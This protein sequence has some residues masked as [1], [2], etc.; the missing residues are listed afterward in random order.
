MS[1]TAKIW[2]TFGA[3]VVAFFALC[4][5]GDLIRESWFYDRSSG[6]WTYTVAYYLTGIIF[7]A[8][9]FGLMKH[10]WRNGQRDRMVICVCWAGIALSVVLGRIA[11]NPDSN[12]SVDWDGRSNPTVCE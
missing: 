3:G 7:F 10:A 2:W 6:D 5:F 8:S 4:W 12:C 11:T 1:S 9:V